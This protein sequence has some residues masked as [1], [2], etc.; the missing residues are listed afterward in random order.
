[1]VQIDTDHSGGPG[2]RN[3]KIMGLCIETDS[4][5]VTRPQHQDTSRTISEG[6]DI[7]W[8]TSLVSFC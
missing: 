2:Y 1:M 6:L 4:L 7:V 8:A 3:L 5:L